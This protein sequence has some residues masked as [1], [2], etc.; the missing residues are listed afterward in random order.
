MRAKPAGVAR[1][2]SWDRLS[3]S[4]ELERSYKISRG[5]KQVE[6]C[7]IEGDGPVGEVDWSS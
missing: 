7:A 4:A 3:S 6:T 5:Q 1:A 2:V